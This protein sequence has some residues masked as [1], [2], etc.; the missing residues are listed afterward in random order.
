VHREA[1]ADA[2]QL[3]RQQSD[4]GS[5]IREVIVQVPHF[6]PFQ[7][8]CQEDAFSEVREGE[9]QAPSA[10]LAVAKRKPERLQILSRPTQQRRQVGADESERWLLQDIERSIEL[11]TVGI[12]SRLV[13]TWGSN[14]ERIDGPAQLPEGGNFTANESVRSG[15]VLAREV[16]QL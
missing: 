3:A 1:P 4:S 15:W 10:G 14:T 7:L 5:R 2:E 12:A 9:E 8:A 11:R 16:G 13:R 6:D